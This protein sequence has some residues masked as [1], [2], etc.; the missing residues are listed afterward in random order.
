MVCSTAQVF[1][2]TAFTLS[3]NI[4][5]EAYIDKTSDE[6]TKVRRVRRKMSSDVEDISESQNKVLWYLNILL[7]IFFIKK[8]KTIMVLVG[9]AGSGLCILLTLQLYHEN[10]ATGKAS[11]TY[12]H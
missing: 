6:G 10:H 4:L 8:V 7:A 9:I 5:S 11:S 12:I 3:S 2:A 1:S